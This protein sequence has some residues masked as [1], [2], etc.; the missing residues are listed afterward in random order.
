VCKFL[1]KAAATVVDNGAPYASRG[2]DWISYDSVQ[3][4]VLKSLWAEAMGL[5]GVMPYALQWDDWQ[6]HCDN[7]TRFPIHRAIWRAIG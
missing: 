2:H 1:K 5:G 4:A 7:K 6:G 3:S